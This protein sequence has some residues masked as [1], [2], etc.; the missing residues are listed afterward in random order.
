MSI[1]S[2]I[3]HSIAPQRIR[4]KHR[5]RLIYRL[6]EG[7]AT[8]TELASDSNLRMPHAS[9]EIRRMR[10]DGLV[11]SDLPA[12]SRGAQLR[13]TESG[14][15]SLRGDELS[16]A[17]AVS[18]IPKDRNNCCILFRDEANLLLCFLS[19]PSDPM[20]PIPSRVEFT[21]QGRQ[22]STRNLGGHWTWAI[23]TD[24][25]PCWFDLSNQSMLEFPP[26][27]A[28]L[29]SIDAYSD[30][31]P[32]VGVVR[33]TLL[34]ENLPT[35]V[36]PGTWFSPPSHS[37]TPPLEERNYHRGSWSLGSCHGESQEIR[38]TLPMAANLENRLARSM[39]LRL[40]RPGALVIADLSGV[41]FRADP[42]PIE[43]LDHWISLAH[44]RLTEAERKRRVQALKDRVIGGRSKRTSEPTWR[45]FRSDWGDSE[46]TVNNEPNVLDTRALGNIAIESLVRWAVSNP[47][48]PNLVVEVP[49]VASKG[50]VTKLSSHSKLRLV[51]VSE[52]REELEHMDCIALD[53]LR[54]IPWLRLNLSGGRFVPVK[55][56][57]PQQFSRSKTLSGEGIV[58]AQIP[59]PGVEA[60]LQNLDLDDEYSSIV[61][62]AVAQWPEG[63][64]E[65]AN[66][67]EAS[68]PIAAWIASPRVH[69]WPRW[70][71]LRR[72]ISPEW[73]ILMD[74]EQIPLG[75][76]A[77][78]AED[79]NSN[80]LGLLS[81]QF[82]RILRSEPD[83]AFRA[84]PT[85]D[86][87][88]SSS[89]PSWVASQLLAN[90]PWI[91]VSLHDDLIEWSL[92][93]WLENPPE[94]S[95]SSLK[96]VAWLFSQEKYSNRD[97][98]AIL[99]KIATTARLLSQ[100]HDLSLWSQ[101]LEIADGVIKVEPT[102]L[103]KILI[104]LPVDWWAGISP[105]LLLQSL[106]GV[107]HDWLIDSDIPWCAAVLRPR[108]EPSQCPGLHDLYHPGCPVELI[109][110]LERVTS[111]AKSQN[112]TG[113]GMHQLLDLLESLTWSST[114]VAPGFGRTHRF[115][116][117]LAQPEGLW[118]DFS[119]EDL[120]EGSPEIAIRLSLR[121]SAFEEPFS[122]NG[123]GTLGDV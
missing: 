25:S 88:E 34:D 106:E 51:L 60:I 11:S 54:P 96:G 84:R 86:A 41:D 49:R 20:L 75:S 17:M 7:D 50:L 56:S 4:S 57:D 32:V 123:K 26:E 24:T 1:A 72:R 37:L 52:M 43:A 33:A 36:S 94:D 122:E 85:I 47:E 31:P 108:G 8:V 74:L 66:S 53:R 40:A 61:K 119:T 67:V 104:K 91:P 105:G 68:Y 115:V 76:L 103:S 112:A 59:I 65:W 71:R 93:A 10:E 73:L 5:C 82:T 42:Y 6:A 38:P 111:I 62:S 2:D 77:A 120:F 109:S 64:E 48:N 29:T 95:L 81:E 97:F 78:I 113:L 15:M 21:G 116:G 90:S 27:R 22:A 107:S 9:A 46:F 18:E 98:S 121:A 19:N 13:L 35:T 100:E 70:Q 63:N 117:W 39:L 114:G 79:A 118:P 69:R 58:H 89:G 55:L 30:Q 3:G 101:L 16:K 44:P 23:L 87:A 45:R 80:T 28:D 83:S 102:Q 14:W 92:D 110:R 99:D 12:G